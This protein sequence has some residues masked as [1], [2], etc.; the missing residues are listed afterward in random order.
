MLYGPGGVGKTKL[1]SL[2]KDVGVKPLFIDLEQGSLHLD[3]SRIDQIETWEDMRSV[4]HGDICNDFDAIV[5]DSGTKAE[6]LATAWVI[7]NV[8]HEKGKPI[9]SIEDYGFGKGLVHVYET[10]LQL[11][12]DLDALHRRG[13]HIVLICHECVSNAPNPAGDDW[14]RYEPRLQSPTSGKNSIRHRVKEWCSHLLYVGYDVSVD[15]GGK[16]K[17]HGSRTIYPTEQ[18]A[19]WAKS[20][21]LADPIPYEDGDAE[22]WKQL[23]KGGN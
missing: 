17:G 15:E 6:E 13:K 21:T 2:M 1:A 4:L 10:F 19:W 23:I 5:I 14:M 20:R 16:G 7:A 22:L 18:A 3:V 9:H 8:K 11:L 12:G